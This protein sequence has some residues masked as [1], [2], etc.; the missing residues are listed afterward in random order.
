MIPTEIGIPS[1]RILS[2]NNNEEELRLNLDLLEERRELALIREHKYKRQ[3]Q[4]YY[5]SRVQVCK[6]YAGDFVFCNNDALGQEPSGKLAPTWEGPY[7]VKEVLSKGAYKLE[8]L[9]GTEIPRTWN[10]AQL[11]RCYM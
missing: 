6:F 3:L 7:R 11:K 4:I 5:D 2:T 8:K 10:I 1:A 9:D